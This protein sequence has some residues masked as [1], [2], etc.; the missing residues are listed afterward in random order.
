MNLMKNWVLGLILGGLL[1]QGSAAAAT[2]DEVRARGSV[3]CAVDGTAGFGGL[4]RDG[5]PAGLDVEFCRAV[6]AAVLGRADAVELERIN[7]ANKFAALAR[8]E[9]DIAFG[10]ATWTL[11]RD[12]TLGVRFVTP[13]F[14]DGQ[15]LMAW[16]DSR[17]ARLGDA[18]G[19]RVCVQAGTT[20]ADNLAD[21]SRQQGLNLVLVVTGSSEERLSRFLRR[22][23]E[24]LSG[25]RAEL[26]SIR[27]TRT[28][29]P[30]RWRI[31]DET[32]SREPLG[33]Y[34]AAGDEPWFNVVRWVVNATLVAEVHGLTAERLAQVGGD[35]PAEVRMLA[36]QG[37]I[38][39]GGILPG[40][41][42]R[43]AFNV[44]SQ[45]GNYAQI[46]ERTVGHG[47]PLR[48]ERGLNR[49]WRDGGLF[50]PPP[51]R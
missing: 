9:V 49:L 18:R 28:P 21:L 36:G 11:R 1:L 37:D 40:L 4:G 16:A 10:M 20:S 22:D 43:W 14:H 34:V 48:L 19:R 46:F 39:S 27:A 3:R 47:S 38:D 23:C 42:R 2:L 31:L 17:I 45:V 50:F 41:D 7:T 12:A 26:A 51:L 24:L 13:V 25:D 29:D 15:A 6:A 32:L 35:A 33:P 30:A 5:R 8:G 44:L